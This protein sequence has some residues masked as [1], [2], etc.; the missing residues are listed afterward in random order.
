MG[1][2]LRRAGWRKKF[3]VQRDRK[4][5]TYSSRAVRLLICN[6]GVRRN[7]RGTEGMLHGLF[8]VAFCLGQ[9][10]IREVVIP[11]CG[12]TYLSDGGDFFFSSVRRVRFCTRGSLGWLL[13]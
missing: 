2:G 5:V 13:L 10:G 4:V 12:D 6:R 1:S 9:N 8:R 7:L 11:A 3:A